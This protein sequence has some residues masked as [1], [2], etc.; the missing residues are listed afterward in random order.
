MKAGD[1]VKVSGHNRV[2]VALPVTRKQVRRGVNARNPGLYLF[3]GAWYGKDLANIQSYGKIIPAANPHKVIG[4][5]KNSRTLRGDLLSARY[6][7]IS[8][9][10]IDR[11]CGY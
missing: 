4:N 8:S 5:I 11:L 7:K 10:A 9:K 2:W 1:I 6:N 3:G